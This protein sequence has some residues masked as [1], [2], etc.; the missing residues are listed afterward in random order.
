MVV[1]FKTRKQ[2]GMES[3]ADT[4][5]KGNTNR[6]KAETD[7]RAKS[8]KEQELIFFIRFSGSSCSC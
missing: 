8:K 4:K 2:D 3:K 5:A 7:R 6:K 1:L